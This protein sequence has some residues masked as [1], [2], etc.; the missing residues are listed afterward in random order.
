[1]LLKFRMTRRVGPKW[2][3]ASLSDGMPSGFSTPGYARFTSEPV[4]VQD[5]PDAGLNQY[6]NLEARGTLRIG[7]LRVADA[8]ARGA[9]DG[10]VELEVEVGNRNKSMRRQGLFPCYLN[11]S[12]ALP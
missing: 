11:E 4:P 1:M 3:D 7:C 8:I 5:L 12:E 9:V 6:G 2:T 10:W